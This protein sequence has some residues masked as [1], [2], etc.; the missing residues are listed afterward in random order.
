MEKS[1]EENLKLEGGYYIG[2][3]GFWVHKDPKFS[4]PVILYFKDLGDLRETF[5]RCLGT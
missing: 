3:A 5:D 1:A 2:N 4:K